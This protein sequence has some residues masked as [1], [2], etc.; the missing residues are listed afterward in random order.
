M[1][2]QLALE[3]THPRTIMHNLRDVITER[4]QPL[5]NDQ[6]FALLDFPDHSN[7]GDSAIWLGETQFFGDHAKPPAYV[8]KLKTHD[9]LQM[10]QAI[11]DG[12]IFLHGG[13]NFG[14]IWKSHQDFRLELLSRFPGQRIVQLPQSIYFDNYEAVDET[15]RAIEK[16]GSF[17][18][19]VRDQRSLE[20]SRCHFQCEA[21][22]CPDMALYMEPLERQT[23]VHDF[24]YLMRTDFERSVRGKANHPGHAFESGD[25]LTE[26]KLQ[27][28]M[29][30]ATSKLMDF[31]HSPNAARALKY[32][33][34]A[35]TRLKRGV[36]L[37]SSG[38]VVV[39]DRL[40]GHIM[41]TL[42]GIPHVALDNS[43][44]KLQNF[45][46]AWTSDIG[47]L[48]TADTLEEAQSLA[49]EL[50]S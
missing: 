41:S 36:A 42:L 5:L 2:E 27:M 32:D 11:G 15:A 3:N 28:R 8:S 35:N 21:V 9:S 18:L 45:I 34:L 37:L 29:S 48:R 26:D 24:Y 46:Q 7:V 16:H 43:Y 6:P 30:S 1:P 12:T 39:T 22:L 25:W 20:F 49:E 40:H 13:G 19:L 47:F 4:L 31:G 33:R 44:G 50:L 10:E 38:R 14:T 17:T 23:P